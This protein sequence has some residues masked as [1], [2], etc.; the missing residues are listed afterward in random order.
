MTAVT[1]ERVNSL[2][3]GADIVEG[4]V[5]YLKIGGSTRKYIAMGG[6]LYPKK[7]SSSGPAT[8]P[9]FGYYYDEQYGST[10]ADPVSGSPVHQSGGNPNDWATSF[11]YQVT[12][13]GQYEFI[14]HIVTRY[15]LTNRSFSVGIINFTTNEP[16]DANGIIY[17]N[18]LWPYVWVTNDFNAGTGYLRVEPKDSASNQ[19]IPVYVR[20]VLTL[21]VGDWI[22][23]RVVQWSSSGGNSL[24][25]RDL[26]VTVEKIS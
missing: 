12:E 14:A 11:P 22:N 3:T 6:Q 2:P 19:G 15:V 24:A 18:N 21:A 4:R 13:A 5:Y 1:F 9:Y 26:L 23:P 8:L 16:T 7:V 25:S 10:R 20:G 17:A